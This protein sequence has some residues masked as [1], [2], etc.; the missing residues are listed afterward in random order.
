[1]RSRNR[2]VKMYEIKSVTKEALNACFFSSSKYTSLYLRA[3]GVGCVERGS[4]GMILFV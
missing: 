3:D 4:F 1:M 2:T